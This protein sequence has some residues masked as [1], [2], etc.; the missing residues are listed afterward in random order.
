MAIP[1]VQVNGRN[2]REVLISQ[3]HSILAHLSDEKT[4]TYMRD[5]VWW[6]TMVKDVSDYCRSCQV[7]AVSKPQSGK[8]HGKLKTMPVPTYPWQYIGVDFVGPLPESSNRDGAFDM[9]CVIIDQ[10]TSMVHLVPSRQTYRATDVAEL[11]FEN[12]YKLHGLPER[13]VSD[14]DSLFTSK[15]WKRLHHLLGTELRMSSAFH[16]QTDGTT[17]RANRT[18]TQMIR[19]CVRPDQKDWVS[20][21]PAIE[22]AVNSAR[23]STT[24]FSPFQLNYGRNPSPMIWKGQ[25]EFPGVRKFAEQMKLAI[26]SAHDSIIAARVINTVQANRKRASADYKVGDL[27]YLSTKNLSLPKGRARKLAPKYL[28]LFAIT[29]VLKEG[30]TYQLDLSEEL[31]KRGI[32]PSFHASLLK[33]HVPSDDRRFPGRLPSQIPG[34]GDK[35]EEWIVEAIVAH[36]GK[37]NRSDFQILWKAGDRTWAPYREVAHL[38]AMYR[39]CELMGVGDPGELPAAYPKREEITRISASAIGL[40]EGYK[41]RSSGG[42]NTHPSAMFVHHFTEA[43]WNTCVLYNRRY[44]NYARGGRINDHPGSPP[45]HFS[46]YRTLVARGVTTHHDATRYATRSYARS[47]EDPSPPS[48]GNVSMPPEA[49]TSFFDAQIRMVELM[50]GG[51]QSAQLAVRPRPAPRNFNLFKPRDFHPFH[52]GRGNGRGRG[53][54]RGPNNRGRFGRARPS[55][56]F[57]KKWSRSLAEDVAMSEASQLTEDVFDVFGLGQE[58]VAG[59][60]SMTEATPVPSD[61]SVVE[62]SAGMI[63]GSSFDCGDV[64]DASFSE[65]EELAKQLAGDISNIDIEEIAGNENVPGPNGKGKEVDRNPDFI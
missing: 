27:V 4:V 28:M 9:I 16:P 49:L 47:F 36:R 63:P 17:E 52:R 20:K 30:A 48:Q 11:M 2:V 60:S 59:P 12:V 22:F 53:R 14:R 46:N 44:E 18:I 21:L 40:S 32:N 42:G 55:L 39:Y 57:N 58:P 29:K 51:T 61:P 38:I 33:P 62:I 43:E 13:I 50:Q 54:G 10:L 31:L 8:P 26:M 23:S 25:E 7:C 45:H 5:Q 41:N 65:T 24:G 64:D 1:D 56:S 6:K 19:Q 3:G 15:F 34:F 35:P 37:G